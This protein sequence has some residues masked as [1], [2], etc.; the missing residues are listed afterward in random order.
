MASKPL[1]LGQPSVAL[2]GG[3]HVRL[4][5]R[6]TAPCSLENEASDAVICHGRNQR[7]AP[8]EQLKEGADNSSLQTK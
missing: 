5:T 1:P 7:R 6:S 2:A 3:D 8:H 4:R